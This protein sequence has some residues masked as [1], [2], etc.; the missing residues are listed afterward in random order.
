MNLYK[1]LILLFFSLSTLF[2]NIKLTIPSN[3]IVKNESFIF[4]I[5]AFGNKIKFPDISEIDGLDVQEISNSTSTNII[6]GQITKR[7][8]KAYSFNPTNDFILP[9]FEAVIDGKNYYTKE[10]KITLQKASK[11]K[12]DVFDL[13]IKTNTNEFYI[14]ENFILTLIF[15]YKKD[16]QVNNLYL[17]KPNFENFF[18]KQIDDTKNYEEG[19]FQVLEIKFLMF[20]VK[21]GILK[22]DPIKINSEIIDNTAYSYSIFSSKK[23]ETIYSNELNFNIK[24]LPE[25]I[26]LI[27]SFDIETSIDKKKVKRGEAVS[28]K[29]RISGIGNIDDINNI[30]LPINDV[31]IYEN[32]PL[33]KTG[34]VNNEY[35]GNYEK[36]FSIIANKSFTIPSIPLEY[37][38]KD[39]KKIVLKQSKKFDIEVL[40]EEL[41]KEV[42]LEKASNDIIKVETP[43][44]I[45]KIVEKSSALDRI[46]F[47]SLGIITSLLIMSL[48]FYVITLKRKKYEYIKPLSKKVKASKTKEEL[49]KILAIY[50][51]IDLRLDKLIFELEKTNDIISLKKEIIKVLKELNL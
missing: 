51:K 13:T 4:T 43:K 25:N 15:K 45:I 16:A 48:Y 1:I 50:I 6:N 14:G 29:L 35:I 7:I 41:K 10:E 8:K 9:S 40:E 37:F 11:T 20:A 49:I 27:G 19:E 12:S 42:V 26:K 30:K 38:D 31:T 33:R 18:Y 32:K 36:V 28:Y 46:V 47:F 44:E 17:E 24:S 39:L 22:I 34:I 5:E 2:A 23:N 21:E 3:T